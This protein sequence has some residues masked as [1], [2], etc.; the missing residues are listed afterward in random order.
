[1]KK[2]ILVLLAVALIGTSAVML[3]LQRKQS[4]RDIPLPI[5]VTLQ[6]KVVSA[7]TERLEQTRPF[8]AQFASKDTAAISSKLSGRIKEVLVKEN[9]AVKEGDLLLEIDDREITAA[10]KSQQITLG[11]RERNIPH[12]LLTL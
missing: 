6:V 2:I 4:V 3:Y 12:T 1:V 10:I 5:P 9:Q 8:L 7:T 11:A